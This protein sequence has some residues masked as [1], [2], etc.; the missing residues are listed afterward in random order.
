[1]EFVIGIL[2]MESKDLIL[3]CVLFLFLFSCEGNKNMNAL[4]VREARFCSV[5]DS[6]LTPQE[7][8]Q[9]M[10]YLY[11]VPDS[12]LTFEQSAI[13]KELIK[14]FKEEVATKYIKV[15]NNEMTF[16]MGKKEF[17][18]TGL[19]ETL[20]WEIKENIKTNNRFIKENG[21]VDMEESWQKTLDGL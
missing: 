20:Y 4:E 1:V 3:S 5:A 6:L 19:P 7:R 9:K 16:T 12:V 21:M 10:D 18:K 17:L 8:K 14:T 11:Y 15:E 2:M 13:K